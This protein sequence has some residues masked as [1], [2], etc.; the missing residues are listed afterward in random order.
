MDKTTIQVSK[1][2]ALKLAGMGAK[3]E[4]YETIIKK[5]IEKNERSAGK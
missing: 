3:G 2:T 4:S 1:E 5:M